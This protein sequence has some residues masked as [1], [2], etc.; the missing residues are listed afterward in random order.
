LRAVLQRVSTA[1]VTVDGQIVGQIG[2]ATT[3]QPSGLL[4]L[5]GVA[6]GDTDEDS[7]FLARKTVELR[8]FEDENGKMNK[9]LIEIGGTV[10]VVSQFTLIADWRNGRRP[11]FSRAAS[12]QEGERLYLHYVD[13]LR[14][15][16]I[17][18]QTGIFGADMQ[19]SIQNE[20]PVTLILDTRE[21]A[22]D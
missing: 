15:K 13:Q 2:N 14:Q 12:P 11:G 1:T 19:V 5:F 7:V 6:G 8:I 18:V 10:L 16:Q 21:K 20:G 17:P 4:V 9:S 3:R 22:A